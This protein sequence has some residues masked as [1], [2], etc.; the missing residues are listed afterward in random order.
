M[1]SSQWRRKAKT[2]GRRRPSRILTSR[3][4]TCGEESNGTHPH[5]LISP[6]QKGRGQ[7]LMRS[8]PAASPELRSAP[9]PDPTYI[10]LY[11]YIQAHTCTHTQGGPCN[12][13]VEQEKVQKERRTGRRVAR[14]TGKGLRCQEHGNQCQTAQREHPLP[15]KPRGT[16]PRNHNSFILFKSSKLE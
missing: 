5:P 12:V 10:S 1:C 6:T 16:T 3:N 9:S 14:D 11:T 13:H 8:V 2:D 15:L 4:A 7:V